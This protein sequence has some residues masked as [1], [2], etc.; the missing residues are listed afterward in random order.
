[1]H[2]QEPEQRQSF[3]GMEITDQEYGAYRPQ[4]RYYEQEQK[5]YPQER[6][7]G[8]LNTL[9]TIFSSLAW[10]PA[11]LGIIA[12]AFVLSQS[13]GSS[14]LITYGILGLVGSGVAL[15]FLVTVFV[16]AVVSK[17]RMA[18]RSRWP[19]FH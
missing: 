16:L 19:R 9:I 4:T 7:E 6:H 3:E 2:M 14:A 10:G 8:I 13:N 12:S 1:M 18:A 15:L 11:M 5:V 17:S